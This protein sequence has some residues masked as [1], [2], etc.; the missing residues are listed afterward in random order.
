MTICL[1]FAPRVLPPKRLAMCRGLATSAGVE[2]RGKPVC[3]GSSMFSGLCGW[4]RKKIFASCFQKVDCRM[5]RKAT[6]V[7]DGSSI[8]PVVC[9]QGR[10]RFFAAFFKRLAMA[11]FGVQKRLMTDR[12]CFLRNS[13]RSRAKCLP[14]R[15]RAGGGVSLH[16][17]TGLVMDRLCFL[18]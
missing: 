14:S 8:F 4:G 6:E 7:D 2:F 15:F 9:G 12:L 10:K 5:I 17:S 1:C 18:N 13:S 3:D 11:C 16:A